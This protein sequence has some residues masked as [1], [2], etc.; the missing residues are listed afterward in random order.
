MA[1]RRVRDAPPIP[2]WLAWWKGDPPAHL[3]D[4]VELIRATYRA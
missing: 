2:V 1:Y 3:D 4:L